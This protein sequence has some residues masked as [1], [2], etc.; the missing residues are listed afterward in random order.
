MIAF[1]FAVIVEPVTSVVRLR[2]SRSV[3]T[4]PAKIPAA[5]PPSPTVIFLCAKEAVSSSAAILTASSAFVPV[6]VIV[7]PVTLTCVPPV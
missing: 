5:R 2:F 4:E 7:L 3:A 1:E 6:A